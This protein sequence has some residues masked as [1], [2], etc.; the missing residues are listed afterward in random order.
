MMLGGNK[1]LKVFNNKKVN[2]LNGASY[3]YKLVNLKKNNTFNISGDKHYSIYNISN[4][5]YFISYKNLTK[6]ITNQILI[7]KNCKIKI[8]SNQ[9]IK[10][11][12]C[13]KNSISKKSQLIIKNKKSIYKVNKPWGYELWINKG[14]KKYCFKEIYIKKGFKTSLQYH[15]YKT[16]TNFIYSGK[17]KLYYSTKKPNNFFNGSIR[18]KVLGKYNSVFVKPNTIHRIEALANLKLFEVS[19]P[20]LSDVIRLNDDTNRSSGKISSEHRK[21]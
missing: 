7:S 8:K 1:I 19:T 15:K 12:F 11:L 17:C 3:F 18:T 21:I 16:E 6:K 9:N 10:L 14:S 13:G 5:Q 4:N 2:N 20:N